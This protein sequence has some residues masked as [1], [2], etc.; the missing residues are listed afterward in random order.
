MELTSNKAIEDAAI[1][2]VIEL[3]SA[4]GRRARDVR[5]VGAAVDIESLPRHI[6]VKAFGRS[7]RGF[8]LPF[9]PRQMEAALSDPDFY[10][11]VVENV[12]QGDPGLFTLR[13]LAGDRLRR[14]LNRAKEHRYF[15]VPWATAEY[16]SCSV[17]L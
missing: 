10:L 16:D 8:E 11:Y 7:G 3:E 6:E 15:S 5:Y 12:R 9:E 14:L 17:G 4:A 13:V 1:R 2:W